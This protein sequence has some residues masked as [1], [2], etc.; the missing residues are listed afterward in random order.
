MTKDEFVEWW[1]REGFNVVQRLSAPARKWWLIPGLPHFA[2]ESY[3]VA[4]ELAK[5]GHTLATE[6]VATFTAIRLTES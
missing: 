3:L 2:Y 5:K 4:V 1:A 6:F